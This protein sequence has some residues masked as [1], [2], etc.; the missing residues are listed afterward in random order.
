MFALPLFL[1]RKTMS[2]KNKLCKITKLSDNVFN[3]E[4]PNGINEGYET[5]GSIDHDIHSL[6][7]F[8]KLVGGS[9][10]LKTSINRYL[11]TSY[12]TSIESID[13]TNKVV[14]FKTKNS[15]YK[16]EVFDKDFLDI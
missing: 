8:S 12:I 7:E 13:E 14:V 1:K 6:T 5:Y 15:T 9:L 3:G 10:Y 2:I 4:H 11:R 16:L